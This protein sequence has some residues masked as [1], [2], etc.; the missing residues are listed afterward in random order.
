MNLHTA[1]GHIGGTALHELSSEC[2]IYLH[3][4]GNNPP[5]PEC[6]WEPPK[7]DPDTAHFF[8]KAFR[9]QPSQ[10]ICRTNANQLNQPNAN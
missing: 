10:R 1:G 3:A 9:S 2:L 8:G 5:W 6:E 7:V 4:N